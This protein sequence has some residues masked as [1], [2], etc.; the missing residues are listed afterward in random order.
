DS[1]DEIDDII[2]SD[3]WREIAPAGQKMVQE[4]HM[5]ENRRDQILKV[6]NAYCA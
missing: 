5:I 3:R 6:Y 2:A 4:R 1:L